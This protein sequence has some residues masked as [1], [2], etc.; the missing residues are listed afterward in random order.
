[1][2]ATAE[3]PRAQT[4]NWQTAEYALSL[5]RLRSVGAIAV[6]GALDGFEAVG[7]I[8]QLRA[9]FD[10]SL[11]EML[12]TDQEFGRELEITR[13]E[14]YDVTN[15]HVMSHDGTTRVVD[16]LENGFRLSSSMAQSDSRMETQ[17]NR[18]WHDLQNALEVEAMARGERPY[19]TRIVASLMPEEAIEADGED[20]WR[21][22]G[23]FPETKTA[24]LQLYHTTSD[25]RLI[26][27]TL[28]VDATDKASMRQLWAELGITV[29]EGESTDNWL[30]YAVTDNMSAAG[31]ELFVKQVRQKH[32]ANVGHTPTRPT[33]VEQV[34]EANAEVVDQSFD[35]L[36]VSLAE[37]LAAGQKTDIV[38]NLIHGFMQRSQQL[39][40][41]LRAGLLSAHNKQHFD[42]R[43]ARTVYKIV[44]YA[45]VEQ[46]R[47]SLPIVGAATDKTKPMLHRH[48]LTPEQSACYVPT[49]HFVNQLVQSALLGVQHNRTYGACG[50]RITLSGGG[51][52]ES[53]EAVLARALNPQEAFGGK[54]EG[55]EANEVEEDSYGPLTFECTEGHKNTRK[56]GELID[57]CQHKHCTGSVGCG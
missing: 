22:M 20:Y 41:E 19:N 24:F 54:A 8:Q 40:P 16:M 9:E 31:A 23:Y 47:K 6:D 5:E 44:M 48:S 53:P 14:T 25:G 26:T 50:A 52:D 39:G 13:F 10:T 3:V 37:S 55:V 49:Q 4:H 56:R 2:V 45:T 34:L 36:Y 33:S 57:E 51:V 46:I 35:Q 17:A 27:G 7:P 38:Q 43:H 21:G 18:D 32:Y 28:S 15:G 30:Q 42:D 1:M 12:K 11:S 29:P